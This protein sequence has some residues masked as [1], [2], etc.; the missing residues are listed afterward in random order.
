MKQH[1]RPLSNLAY[2]D[3][4]CFVER[5]D[6]PLAGGCGPG[7]DPSARQI[8]ARCSTIQATWDERETAFRLI[9]HL[10]G[11]PKDESRT[12]WQPPTVA[13]TVAVE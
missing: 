13:P 12:Y 1:G 5:N 8:R 4:P 3:S 7:R 2:L 10:D 6:G 9:P 11:I